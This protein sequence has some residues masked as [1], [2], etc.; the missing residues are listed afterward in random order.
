MD[1]KKF[2]Q[3]GA[4]SVGWFACRECLGGTMVYGLP[5]GDNSD[6]F[7]YPAMYYKKTARG[8]QC[9]LCPNNCNIT[10]IRP[11]DCK[12]K[13]IR[14]GELVST[15]YGNPYYVN[16]EAPE[17]LS[18]YHF[19]PGTKIWSLGT[20]G[21]TLTCKYCKVWEVS[22]KAPAEVTHREMFPEQVIKNCIEKGIKTIAYS[23]NE[24]VAFFEYMFITAR[25][26]KQHGIQN[27][28]I[29]NGFINEAPLRALAPYLDAVVID[30][31]AFSD[32]TY[33]KL[34]GGS[35]F[36]VF[37]TLKILKEMKVWIEI[38]HLLVPTW[39]DNF[40]LVKKMCGWMTQN[41]FTST[42]LHFNRFQPK[43]RLKQLAPTPDAMLL[44]A[45]QTAVA[46]GVQFVYLD[47]LQ[48]NGNQQTT[49]PKCKGVL[50][51]RTGIKLISNHIKN[52]QCGFCRQPIPGEW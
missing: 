39:T 45:K 4:A 51:E 6:K 27:V 32:A 38:T 26:A 25:L 33:Q 16:T 42:P 47:N 19:K 40:E 41:G 31:K 11:G 2:L 50:I 46:S 24:P 13:E 20:A 12:T 49:C 5:P 36:T 37:N 29:S 44:K 17:S 18:L 28:L 7:T 10:S 1:R 35:I 30:V 48:R 43:Y 21:C 23:Y 22:Q 15:A 14:N 8:I 3:F 9:V 52:G 34:T